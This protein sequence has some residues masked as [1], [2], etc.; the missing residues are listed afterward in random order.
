MH[1]LLGQFGSLVFE[2]MESSDWCWFVVKKKLFQRDTK[3][4]LKIFRGRK[5]QLVVSY[6]VMT[7]PCCGLSV[8]LCSFISHLIGRK[9]SILEIF[10]CVRGFMGRL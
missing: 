3:G 10:S 5:G 1:S 2:Q 6:Q 8:I 4:K 7:D 9:T